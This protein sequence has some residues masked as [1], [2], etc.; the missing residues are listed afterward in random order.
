L[1]QTHEA[2]LDPWVVEWLESNGSMMEQPSDYTAEYLEAARMQTNPFSS[3]EIAK[4]TDH[5]IDGVPVRI[6]EHD[7]RGNGLLVY[8]HGGGFCVGSIGL[9]ETI[10]TELAT[11]ADCTV[12][13]VGYRLAPEDPFPAGLNDCEAVTR[14]ALDNVSSIVGVDARVVVG[15]ESA[16]GNLS[17]AVALRLRGDVGSELAGQ[18][19]LYPG[20]EGP[21]ADYPSRRQCSNQ[22]L[23]REALGPMWSMYCGGR[24]LEH[25][26]FAAPLQADSLAGLP[27]ALVVVGECDVLRDEGLRYAERLCGEGV[28][29]EQLCV[30]GQPHGFMNLGFPAAVEAYRHIGPWLQARFDPT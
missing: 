25:D 28:P 5:T 8:F 11:C 19:L 12:I 24:D 14:W 3:P 20:L 16:G 1:H 29:A 27:P 18:L 9:M 22:M 2:A 26:Q 15:G 4:V 7:H 6:Y 23:R 13:S 10:A 17:A 30:R 21:S